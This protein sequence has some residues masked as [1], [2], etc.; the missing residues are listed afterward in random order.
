MY[1][2]PSMQ[3]RIENIGPIG[4]AV[5]DLAG[6]TVIGGLNDTGKSTIGKSLF[7]IVK[8]IRNREL[9]YPSSRQVRINTLTATLIST[10]RRTLNSSVSP[11]IISTYIRR[12]IDTDS[13]DFENNPARIEGNLAVV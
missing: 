8:A 11:S 3:L 12:A 5:I 4:S 1:K 2:L 10:L 6:L 9:E 7:S 13:I